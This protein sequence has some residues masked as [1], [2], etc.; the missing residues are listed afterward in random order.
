M[1]DVQGKYEFTGE[2]RTLGCCA[3]RQIRAIRD[4]GHIKAGDI[5]GWIEKESN[6]SHYG[7]AWV[8]ENAAVYGNAWVYSRA[9][10]DGCADVSKDGDILWIGGIGSRND[11]TTFYLCKDRKIHVI[12]G[13]F[14]GTIDEFAVAV[15]MTH[16]NNKHARVYKLAIQM[17]KEQIFGDKPT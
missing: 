4:F 9:R 16:E 8:Y 5:G 7:D 3:L 17:A 6:L 2:T 13:C 1:C 14:H 12:C 15:E 11:T 10:V